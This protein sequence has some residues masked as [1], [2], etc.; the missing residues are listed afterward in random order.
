MTRFILYFLIFLIIFRLLKSVIQALVT[1]RNPTQGAPAG[2]PSAELKKDPVC[3][4]YV[5]AGASLTSVV[6]GQTMYFCSE[7]CRSKYGR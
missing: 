5:A 1:P 4:T 2:A 3:G 6:G 7:E